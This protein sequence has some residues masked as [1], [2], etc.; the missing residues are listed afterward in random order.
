MLISKCL[1]PGLASRRMLA[2]LNGKAKENL[3][4]SLPRKGDW[5]GVP[6]VVPGRNLKAESPFY[7]VKRS[8]VKKGNDS[9]EDRLHNL[10]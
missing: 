3:G 8:S 5:C 9:V 6:C 2:K 4:F 1:F 7:L 10:P